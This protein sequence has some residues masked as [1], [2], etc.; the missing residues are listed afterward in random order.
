M[1]MQSGVP[2]PPSGGGD[3]T[4]TDNGS[5][6]TGWGYPHTTLL[7]P[8]TD[9]RWLELWLTNQDQVIK[10]ALHNTTNGRV[11]ELMCASALA[12]TGIVWSAEQA[13]HR[14]EERRVGKECR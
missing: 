6:T 10:L 3:D 2:S 1:T 4:N 14:S 7:N 11:Y 13:M 9:L 12:S 5:G 8:P